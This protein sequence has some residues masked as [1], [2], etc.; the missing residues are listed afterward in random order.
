[1]ECCLEE[2][3]GASLVSVDFQ[4]YDYVAGG[5]DEPE[6]LESCLLFLLRTESGRGGGGS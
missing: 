4:V 5:C 3:E 2:L 6:A 1:L